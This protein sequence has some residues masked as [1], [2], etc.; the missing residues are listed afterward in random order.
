MPGEAATF[1]HDKTLE[2]EARL[3]DERAF[4]VANVHFIGGE[5]VRA[6]MKVPGFRI[7]GHPASLEVMPDRCQ[8]G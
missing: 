1:L 3:V 8:C 5:Y 7:R 4:E 6:K 2:L